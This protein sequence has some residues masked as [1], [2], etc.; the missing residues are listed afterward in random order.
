[1][2]PTGLAHRSGK[3]WMIVHVCERCG[4][5]HRTK[6]ALDDP[7]QPDDTVQVARLSGQT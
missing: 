2:R 3:G 1:M 6:A 4:H 5:T 7:E